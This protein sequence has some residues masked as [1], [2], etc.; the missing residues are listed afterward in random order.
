MRPICRL[1]CISMFLLDGC[2]LSHERAAPANVVIDLHLPGTYSAIGFY[3]R[4]GPSLGMHFMQFAAYNTGEGPGTL[5]RVVFDTRVI[6]IDADGGETPASIHDVLV[7][8]MIYHQSHPVPE[9][10]DPRYTASIVDEQIIFDH[11]G[12]VVGPEFDGSSMDA[13]QEIFIFCRVDPNEDAVPY[14]GRL[15]VWMSVDADT[16][17]TLLE[18]PPSQVNVSPSLDRNTDPETPFET[19][20]VDISFDDA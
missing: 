12:L 17:A 20:Y 9:E 11:A 15:R 2:Y 1:F 5:N 4:G 18:G 13:L 10:G 19:T 7:S 14:R 6:S 8:C 16:G 3:G